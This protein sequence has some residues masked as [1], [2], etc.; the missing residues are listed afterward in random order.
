MLQSI[1]RPMAALAIAGGA[2][3]FVACDDDPDPEEARVALCEDYA[4]LTQAQAD[5]DAL[6]DSATFDQFEDAA[7]LVIERAEALQESAEDYL[8]ANDDLTD[9]YAQALEALDD[10]ID[11]LSSDM[12]V[13]DAKAQIQDEYNA[14]VAARD[15]LIASA[16]CT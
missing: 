3:A 10:A 9:S 2:I 12:T 13:G 14:A 16:N 7:E 1:L 11:N 4:A 15:E 5:L 8:E 6:D